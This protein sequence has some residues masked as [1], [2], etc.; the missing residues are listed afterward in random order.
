MTDKE[1]FNL[2]D[3]PWILCT[4][5]ADN[6]KALSIWDIF[7]GQGDARKIVGDSPTQDYAVI[8]LLLAIWGCPQ[9]VDTLLSCLGVKQRFSYYNFDQRA[10]LRNRRGLPSRWT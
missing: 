2:L 3:K 1:T 7:S 9:I 8:R 4:D 5:S 10:G 6:R